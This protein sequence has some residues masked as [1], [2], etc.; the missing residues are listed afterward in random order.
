MN[1]IKKVKI[2]KAGDEF[3]RWSKP[4]SSAKGWQHWFRLESVEW[5]P[6]ME[7]GVRTG[8][9]VVVQGYH[10]LPVFLLILAVCAPTTQR[11]CHHRP[12]K[13]DQVRSHQQRT[14]S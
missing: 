6:G 13:E 14:A 11:N 1:A 12:P 7:A 3:F 5:C 9:V 8:V 10:R 2:E 4:E